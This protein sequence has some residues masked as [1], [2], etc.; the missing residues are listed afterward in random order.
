MKY[1][2]I[3]VSVEG[4]MD[5]A[6]VNMYL[7]DTPLDKV[8]YRK[9]PIIVICPGGGYEKVSYREG[10]PLAMHFLNKGYHACVLEYSVSP[11][12]F[13][14]PL[15]ELGSVM[16]L[17]HEKSEEWQIDTDNIFVHGASAGGHLVGMLG[18]FWQEEWLRKTLQVEAEVLRPAGVIFSYPVITSDEKYSHKGSF[19]N[20][21]GENYQSDKEKYSLE[22]Q[23]SSNTPPCFLWHTASDKTVPVENSFFMAMA[24]KNAGVPV[25]MHILPE[26]EHGLSLA[27]DIVRRP[28]GSGYHEACQCWIELASAWM[29][30]LCD[31]K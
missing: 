31:E 5:Y 11:A 15:L 20:L 10:E 19:I 22:K 26:G 18:V 9:R 14:T 3:P 24:L 1:L 23:V 17:L 4:S 6:K 12:K 16:K 25:E 27:S 7:L 21:L 2:E 30:R 13:P 28:D 29:A 8:W